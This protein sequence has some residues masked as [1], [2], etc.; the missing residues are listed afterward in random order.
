MLFR[1]DV[2]ENQKD[3]RDTI[4]AVYL[5]ILDL[6]IGICKYNIMKLVYSGRFVTKL[7]NTSSILLTTYLHENMHS[8]VDRGLM[9]Q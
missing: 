2:K 1:S 8:N 7:E 6:L 4:D 9:K 3:R 5:L